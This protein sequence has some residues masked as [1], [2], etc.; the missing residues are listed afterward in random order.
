MEERSIMVKVKVVIISFATLIAS[1]IYT[2]VYPC[3]VAV[4]SARASSTGR[5]FIWKSR[6]CSANWH[7]EI[8]YFPAVTTKAGAYIMVIGFDDLAGVNTGSKVNPSGGVNEAGFAIACTSVY[9]DLNPMHEA[10]NVNTD[11]IRHGLEQCATLADFEAYLG[12]WR[13]DHVG[14]VIS[15]NFCA[16]DAKGG[17]AMYECYTGNVGGTINPIR[18]RKTDANTGKITETYSGYTSVIDKGAGNNFIGFVNLTNCNAYITYNYGEERRWRATDIFTELKS[19]GRLNYRNCMVEVTKD[20]YGQ[21]IDDNGHQLDPA[22]CQTDYSTTY[23]ISRNQTRLGLVVDGVASGGDPRLSAFWCVL[24]EP[25]VAVY[26]PYFV[27]AGGVS[28]LAYIDDIDMDGKLYDLNDTSL[29]ARAS[30]RREMFENLLY[31]SNYGSVL[32]GMEDRN[33]NKLKLAEVQLWTYPLE[34]FIFRKYEEFMADLSVHASYITMENMRAFSDYCA[35]HVYTNY[36]EASAT[37]FAWTYAK[38]WDSIWYGYTRPGFENDGL[39]LQP[40][41]SSQSSSDEGDSALSLEK[42]IGY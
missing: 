26:V 18:W 3:D 21:Q 10:V 31:D 41:L 30:N 13:R 22:N 5:P 37:Q 33:I 19:T 6:D 2:D 14:K 11:L 36:N 20:V 23:C 17:A 15:G 24:G 12:A 39:T 42:I 27:T 8:K 35:N 1:L 9:E 38:P 40:P 7:Q 34:D 28:W 4:V 32:S 29:L 16:I 25:A